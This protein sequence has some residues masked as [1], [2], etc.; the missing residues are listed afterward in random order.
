MPGAPARPVRLRH[1]GR[2]DRAA[3]RRAR[4]LRA[5]A[6]FLRRARRRAVPGLGGEGPV[7]GGDSAVVGCARGLPFAP[8]L[9][10]R[11]AVALRG[12]LA[13]AARAHPEGRGGRGAAGALLGPA[14]VSAAGR[15]CRRARIS[16][17]RP[18]GAG[19]HGGGR[20]ATHGRRRAGGVPAE[21]RPGLI[22]GAG[23]GRG[24]HGQAGCGLHGGVRAPPVRRNPGRARDG[25]RGGSA[26]YRGHAG[27]RGVG[28]PFR[29]RDPARRDAPV[30]HARRRALSA[31]PRRARS[32]I[33]VGPGGGG[34][35]RGLLRLRVP[36]RGGGGGRGR[37]RSRQTAAHVA[38]AV[39]LAGPAPSGAGRRLSMART[40]CAA[41]ARRPLALHTSYPRA[42]PHPVG[43]LGGFPARLRRIRPVPRLLPPLPRERGPTSSPGASPPGN[44][45]TSGCTRSS[46][47]TISPRTGWTWRTAWR[48][49]SPSSTTSSSST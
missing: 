8:R 27:R 4:P 5:Q 34:G 12:D 40:H 3:L 44:S 10:G 39:A 6:A 20:R 25:G 45:S 47:T 31:R 13:G 21:R 28:R 36:A 37:A 18:A 26:P 2:G 15:G 9:S 19:A 35:R 22:V 38:G 48:C 16:G 43:V 23:R 11:E 46:S 30:Q 7:R 14:A 41:V 42:R 1:L 29:R 17:R 24:A 32:R 49:G 33:P